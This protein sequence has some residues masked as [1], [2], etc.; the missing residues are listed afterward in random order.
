MHN[1]KWKVAEPHR[2]NK[3]FLSPN[4]DVLLIKKMLEHVNIEHL[5]NWK[6]FFVKHN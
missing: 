2:E 3:A 6:D 5:S 1:I 4:L